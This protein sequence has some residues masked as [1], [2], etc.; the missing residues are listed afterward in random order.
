MDYKTILKNDLEEL[1]RRMT[2]L[3]PQVAEAVKLKEKCEFDYQSAATKVRDLERQL[4]GGGLTDKQV[5]S[6]RNQLTAPQNEK[7]KYYERMRNAGSNY[8]KLA[9]ELSGLEIEL[10]LAEER[11]NAGKK[12]AEEKK[13]YQKLKA[14]LDASRR[15]FS[16]IK[17]QLSDIKTELV[18]IDEELGH[19]T[20]PATAEKLM[21]S[22]LTGQAK[23][24]AHNNQ[25]TQL[26][27]AIKGLEG[28]LRQCQHSYHVFDCLVSEGEVSDFF[29]KYQELL[30]THIA[31]KQKAGFSRD[32]FIRFQ[33]DRELIEQAYDK[34]SI[35]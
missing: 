12:M 19:V 23:V 8:S 20:D 34:L 14:K 7:Q 29:G 25:L 15:E 9:S 24:S 10:S 18:N 1:K 5:L 27:E 31:K 11:L 32:N 35:R 30:V 6:L 28:D 16:A 17:E 22:K 26:E 33:P 13:R 21:S 4:H 2:D 3:E